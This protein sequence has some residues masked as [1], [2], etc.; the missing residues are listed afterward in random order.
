MGY[1][2]FNP[3]EGD[4]SATISISL[5]PYDAPAIDKYLKASHLW[6]AFCLSQLVPYIKSAKSANGLS[7]L[8]CDPAWGKYHFWSD[9]PG[10]PDIVPR[11]MC[12]QITWVPW[13]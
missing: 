10:I 1:A 3:T 13:A 9:S 11:A 7:P 6:L 12:Y 8:P 5:S 4:K 2:Y